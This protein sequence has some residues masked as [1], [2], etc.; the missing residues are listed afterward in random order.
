MFP[1]IHESTIVRATGTIVLSTVKNT[2]PNVVAR[3]LY[4]VYDE[5]KR[6]E[7]ASATR[8]DKEMFSQGIS[9]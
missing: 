2:G 3:S 8:H 9:P 7:I 6:G 1:L 5:L 4:T